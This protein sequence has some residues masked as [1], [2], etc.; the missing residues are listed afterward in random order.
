MITATALFDFGLPQY[1]ALGLN[2][3]IEVLIGFISYLPFWLVYTQWA[4]V[5][6]VFPQAHASKDAS[7]NYQLFILLE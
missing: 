5:F 6:K 3:D 7:L 4:F 1:L 2:I